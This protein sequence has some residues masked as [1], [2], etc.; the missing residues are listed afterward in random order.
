LLHSLASQYT[1]HFGNLAF[2]VPLVA[3][4]LAV[5]GF[6]VLEAQQRRIQKEYKHSLS[7]LLKITFDFL[8]RWGNL[9]FFFNHTIYQ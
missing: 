7:I 3:F 4:L 9:F 8:E 6:E 5:G 1:F 2:Y